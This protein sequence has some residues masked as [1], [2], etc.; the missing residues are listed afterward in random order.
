MS[1]NEPTYKGFEVKME[2]KRLFANLPGNPEALRY[3]VK[4]SRKDVG[5]PAS[6]EDVEAEA[7][8]LAEA[9]P[10]T[11]PLAFLRDEEGLYLRERNIRGLLKET[12]TVL[13]KRIHEQLR[14]G[15]WVEPDHIHIK[16]G[17]E[18]VKA[19]D[20]IITEGMKVWPTRGAVK[21]SEYVDNVEIE[22]TAWFVPQVLRTIGGAEVVD[23]LF[24]YGQKVGLGGG[25]SLGEGRYR[26]R[27]C[28]PI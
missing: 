9:I 4:A 12:A 28:K 22:F 7:D 3:A 14:H 2:F 18:P 26:L 8:E 17:G 21:E 25:R 10:V 16:R 1:E 23:E 5:L 15:M 20:G 6:K 19:S 27:K 24:R 13:K 11:G